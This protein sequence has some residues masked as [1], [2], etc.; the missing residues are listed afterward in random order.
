MSKLAV[1]IRSLEVHDRVYKRSAM[2]VV[3]FLKNRY[4][5]F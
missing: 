2:E 5:I 4:K 3:K 1:F